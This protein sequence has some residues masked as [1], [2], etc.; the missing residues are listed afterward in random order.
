MITKLHPNLSFNRK[1]SVLLVL[2]FFVSLVFSLH[3]YSQTTIIDPTGDGGFETGTDFAANGWSDNTPPQATR[4][5]WICDTGATAGFTGSNAAYVTNDRT[6]TPPPHTYTNTATRVSHFYR[7]VTIPAGEDLITLDFSWIADAEGNFDYMRIWA[8]PTTFT[9]T[10][11]TQIG[12]AGTAP[13]GRVQIGG[14]FSEQYTW[15][16]STLFLPTAYAGTTFRLVFEWRNDAS[17]GGNPPIGIDNISLVSEMLM[18]PS[19]DDPCNA[20]VLTVGAGCAFTASTTFGA[21]DTTGVPAPGCAS[22]NGGDVWFEVTVPASGNLVIDTID[23][24]ITDSGMAV[25]SVTAACP[26]PTLALVECDDDDSTN[27]FM[28]LI[29]LTGRTP[30]ETLYIRFWEFDNDNPG[31]FGI[32]ASEP[33]GPPV[34]DECSGAIS[35]TSTLTCSYA[36]YTNESATD[37]AGVPAPGCGFYSGGDVWFSYVVNATG[38]LT[39]DTQTGDITDSG[40]AVYSGTCGALTLIE[41]DD[42]DSPNGA[43]SFINLTGRTPGE[44]LYIRVWE[45]GNNNNGVFSICITSPLPPET[46]GVF[47]GCPG[48]PSQPLTSTQPC[49]GTTSLGS[50]ISGSLNAATDLTALQPLIFIQ[51]ND[52]C[53]FDATDT[54]NYTI[55]NFT[56]TDTGTYVFAMDTPVPYFDAMGYIVVNDGN[57]V[58]GSCAT[59]TYIAGDDD[60]GPALDPQITATLTA[61]VNYSL[62]T[63]KFAFG[64]TTHTGSF[65][66]VVTG[67]S[68]DIEWYTTAAGGAP[69]GSGASFDP[70]GVAGS[71][72]PDTNTPGIYSFW[73]ACPESPSTRYQADFVIGK[74]WNGS[75]D[76]NWNEADNWTPSGIPTSTECLVIPSTANDP[77]LLTNDTGDGYNLAVQNGATL[78]I[79][80]GASVTIQDI[81][82]IQGTGTF[83]I[84]DTASLI[85]VNNV[86]NTGNITLDRTANIRLLDYVYWS[87]PTATFD[88]SNVS[89]GTP[90]TYVIQWNPSFDRPD[91]PPPTNVPNDYG[92]WET[93]TGNMILGK[94]YAIKGPSGHPNTPTDYTATFTGVPNNGN[95][96]STIVRGINTVDTYFDQSST[97]ITPDDDNWN[98]I[99]NP[100]PSAISAVDFLT[101]NTNIDG[102]VYLWSH[103]T[104]PNPGSADPFYDDYVYN[105]EVAD[106]I[107]YNQTGPS[108]Q[109]GFDGYIAS[110]QG[111]FVL[112]ND[113]PTPTSSSVS[114]N[115]TMRQ[116]NA[117]Y[118]NSQFYRLGSQQEDNITVEKHR[119]W[120]DMITPSG[121]TNTTLVGYVEGATNER[122]R[123]YDAV[124]TTGAGFDIY[125]VID[126]KAFLIQGK[127]T[128]FIDTDTVPLGVNLTETGIYSIAI[129]ALDGLF[130]SDQ[131]IY[132]EDKTLN[133]IHNLKNAPYVFTIDQIETINDR[134]E[135]RYNAETLSVNPLDDTDGITIMTPKSEYIEVNSSIGMI[136]NIAIYDIVGR[137]I[138]SATALNKTELIFNDNR[139]SDGAY[140]VKVEL[141]NGKQ[142]I[143]KV[144]LRQ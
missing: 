120:L 38:E 44:T 81:V 21:T 132:L 1:K 94:G 20:T 87:S 58:P 97:Q 31:T 93:A 143:Q 109:N 80:T 99:G 133:I 43:M 86:T 76:T 105:Y 32:C 89:S 137:V 14:N 115:N 96:S 17:L 39:I 102:V 50:N 69:I 116:L 77:I 26:T 130:S 5:Q 57:F 126:D 37:S 72:L 91:G 40:M 11:G 9:P 138:F 134:F 140:I 15:G 100:Y 83:Q 128:P 95:I 114:F 48:D 88:V 107:A 41:C 112:M 13:T 18:P 68:V 136:S 6:A 52:P 60:D 16:N 30:G 66:W 3:S 65:N 106:Y 92:R 131:D 117:N 74:T 2:T 79:Q 36:P 23:G 98:L 82:D 84:D 90:A 122:D 144:V 10:Y 103:G 53:G 59:G 33:A 118:D 121:H 24:E 67:P 142:K 27:G 75:V 28:S 61:G 71:G 55:T 19:N 45:Y 8:V 111:F 22:Y 110:G 12:V 25:Y 62:I 7:D 35:L 54:S 124:T 64:N 123:M 70:V 113:A 4:N 73:A 42:D 139:L 108:T 135:L 47:L 56:V 125:S 104:Q 129:N 49:Q 101:T 63:T 85:Q 34:N 119:I 51:S 141:V 29:S 46:N 127:Q 78:T